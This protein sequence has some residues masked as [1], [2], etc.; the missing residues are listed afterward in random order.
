MALSPLQR[1]R[2]QD[3]EEA[4]EQIRDDSIGT[5]TSVVSNRCLDA[6]QDIF[7]DERFQIR[8]AAKGR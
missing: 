1:E 7:E 8:Q 2:L 5:N 3:I 4:L 6:I